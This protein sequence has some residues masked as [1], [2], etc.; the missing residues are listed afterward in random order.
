MYPKKA[1]LFHAFQRRI[2]YCSAIAHEILLVGTGTRTINGKSLHLNKS[3]LIT[4]ALRSAINTVAK[5]VALATAV[6]VRDIG[7]S[8]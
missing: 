5:R 8:R 4:M 2:S 1:E 6:Q 7:T 3:I